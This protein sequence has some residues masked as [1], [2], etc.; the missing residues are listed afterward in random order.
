MRL[1]CPTCGATYGLEPGLIA[2]GGQHV[3]CSACHSR[4]FVA[5]EP[6]AAPAERLDEEAILARLE[7]RTEGPRA[8]PG[9]RPAVVAERSRS[10][11]AADAPPSAA[12]RPGGPA[13]AMA[14]L[15]PVPSS[16]AGRLAGREFAWEPAAGRSAGRPALRVV[17]SSA[18]ALEE[19]PIGAESVRRPGG[20]QRLDLPGGIDPAPPSRAR[21]D[22]ETPTT[23]ISPGP[24]VPAPRR[25]FGRGLASGLGLVLLAAGAYHWEPEIGEALPALAPYAEA[26][27][28]TID[29]GRLWLEGTVG[30]HLESLRQGAIEPEQP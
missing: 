14:G 16:A 12:G 1:T 19:G 26:Y 21:L 29:D 8:A 6:V 28:R 7:R 13:G 17:E 22:L 5:A 30:P 3:Q 15:R 9:S 20:G 23:P 24:A 4:W 10:A 25:R 11:G 2:P 27:A 18:A